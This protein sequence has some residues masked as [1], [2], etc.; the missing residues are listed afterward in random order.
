ME[1]IKLDMKVS[2]PHSME[3]VFVQT[4]EHYFRYKVYITCSKCDRAH[5]YTF[6]NSANGTI[7]KQELIDWASKNNSLIYKPCEIEN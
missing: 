1:T 5:H 7:S 2:T 6:W 3:L 4:D